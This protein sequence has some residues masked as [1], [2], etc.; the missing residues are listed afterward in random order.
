M[1]KGPHGQKRS[2]DL[3][4]GGQGHAATGDE[5]RIAT[6]FKSVAA[7]LSAQQSGRSAAHGARFSRSCRL[8]DAPSS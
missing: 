3:I 7:V 8:A 5:T 4:G 2:A 1:P 6:A